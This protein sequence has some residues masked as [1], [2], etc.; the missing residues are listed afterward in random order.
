MRLNLKKVK[1]EMDRLK[2]NQTELAEQMGCTRAN[3][4]R[5][6][7]CGQGRTFRVIEQ[8]AKVLGCE[9]KDLIK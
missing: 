3:V 8:L 7:R 1:L 2:W 9:P 6:F 5:L 4:S